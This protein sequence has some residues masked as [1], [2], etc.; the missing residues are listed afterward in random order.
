[1]A[2]SAE[3][4]QRR[5]NERAEYNLRLKKE[6]EEMAKRIE[7]KR[8][9]SSPPAIDSASRKTITW[10]GWSKVPANGQRFRGHCGR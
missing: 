2:M 10:N 6:A 1:M 9:S 7:E 4:K 8:K 3:E 5:K